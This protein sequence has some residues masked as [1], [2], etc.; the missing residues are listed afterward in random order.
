M[1]LWVTVI[2]LTCIYEWQED[3]PVNIQTNFV[4]RKLDISQVLNDAS[5]TCRVAN[6]HGAD[7]KTAIVCKLHCSP[8]YTAVYLYQHDI[9][10]GF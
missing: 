1:K 8:A 7:T 3:H 9:F 6:V 10:I 2:Y 4:T 5:Y